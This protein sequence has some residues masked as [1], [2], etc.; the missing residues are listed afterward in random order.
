MTSGKGR[1]WPAEWNTYQDPMT[2][3]TVHQLTDYYAHSR[4]SYFTNPCWYANATK[5]VIT[6][7]RENATNLYSVDLKTGELLQLTD[8]PKELGIG[9]TSINPAKDEVVFSQGKV[10]KVLDLNTLEE[11][12]IYEKP[13]GWVGGGTNVTADGKYLITSE[14]D[15]LSD[16]I[17]TDMGHGY[18]GF[19]EWF[20]YHPQSK[21]LKVAMDGSGQ[22]VIHEDRNWLGHLNPSPK[23]R[24]I[25]TICHEGPWDLVEQRM[26][27]LNTDTGE[28]YPLRPQ[29]SEESVGHEYW[30][31]DGVHVGYH[32]KTPDGEM[33]GSI[34]YDNSDRV[35]APFAYH[36]WHYHSYFLDQVVGDGTAANPYLLLW[37]M[38][39]GVFEG[40]KALAWHRGSFHIQ[41]VH[42]HPCFSPDGKQIAFTADPQGY[43]QAFLVEIPDWDDLPDRSTLAAKNE[44]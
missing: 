16:R 41:N 29:T 42:V 11:R 8:Y 37:R 2:G 35:E 12:T 20:E 10:I 18:V 24:N 32:G 5:M 39:D 23:V 44:V 21:I 30:M 28:I 36:S 15:D 43:G 33:Y 40:P 14:V 31:P 3:A 27:V 34:H 13:D 9:G 7:D 1:I 38:K 22:E 25:M 17:Y 4:H 6:S 26:W 19:R